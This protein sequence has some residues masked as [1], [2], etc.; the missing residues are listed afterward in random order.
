MDAQRFGDTAT[1]TLSPVQLVAGS[2]RRIH[3]GINLARDAIQ[4][5]GKSKQGCGLLDLD[6]LAGFDWLVMNWVYMV[7]EKKGVD[8]QVVNRLQRLYSGSKT[9]VVVNNQLGRC[10]PNNRGSL[11]QGDVPSMYWFGVGIDPLL[12]YLEKRLTGI[13]ITSL[14][15][16]GPVEEAAAGANSANLP[17]LQQRYKVVAYADDVKPSIT[18]MHEFNLVDQAC[19]LLERASG[20]K[21]HRD[22]AAGKVKFLALGRWRGVLTQEDIPQQYIVLSDHLDF[23]GV[24]LRCTFTQTRK[25]NGDQLQSRVKNTV[26]PWKAGKFMP[27]TTRPYS[28]NTFALSKVWFK[29]SSIN[30]R[31]CDITKINSQVKSWLYQDCFEKPSEITLYRDSRDGG[32]GLHHVRLRAQ[33]LLIRSFIETAANPQFRHSLYH[34]ILFR[35]HVLGEHTLPDPGLSPYYDKDFFATIRHYYLTCP[36]NINVMT[37]KQWY[38]RRHCSEDR[39]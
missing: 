37:I 19:A 39:D 21:L 26:G 34:E 10:I 17:D 22:P 1:H 35:Y 13:P 23:V 30:L 8:Q 11:R 14:P 28:A 5:A 25:V 4:Q 12:V 36:M 32:L 15:V 3:H 9:V 20:V 6:F 38:S 31:L 24:E 2:D 29:C 7:L 27:I 16:Q 33:A 18:S